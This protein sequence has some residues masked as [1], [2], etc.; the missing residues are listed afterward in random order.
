MLQNREKRA[1]SKTED[2]IQLHELL[3]NLNLAIFDFWNR[4]IKL[5]VL[6]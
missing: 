4:L 5:S 2:N 3:Q 6:D 1:K